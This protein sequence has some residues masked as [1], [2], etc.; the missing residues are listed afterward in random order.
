MI[1][2]LGREKNGASAIIGGNARNG[3]TGKTL[4]GEFGNMQ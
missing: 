3:K 4:R 2:H 1:V